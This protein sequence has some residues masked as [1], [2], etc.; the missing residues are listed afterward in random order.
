VTSSGQG[1]SL[2]GVLKQLNFDLSVSR[3]GC[4]ELICFDVQKKINLLNVPLTILYV[5][6]IMVS[7][8]SEIDG[9]ALIAPTYHIS[10]KV[11][12]N[13]VLTSSVSAIDT[14]DGTL[15]PRQ[16][17]SATTAASDFMHE[18]F[19]WNTDPGRGMKLRPRLKSEY[20]IINEAE[21]DDAVR[22][23]RKIAEEKL[24]RVPGKKEAR[25]MA[26]L[27][28]SGKVAVRTVCASCLLS[29]G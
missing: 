2:Y 19:T 25:A 10:I 1:H 24:K 27:A 14:V 6:Q 15:S 22:E 28:W 21:L 4:A 13:D 7:S 11:L 5:P 18:H 26:R 29:S 8:I 9:A 17:R 20:E 16:H 23:I 12:D 3:H